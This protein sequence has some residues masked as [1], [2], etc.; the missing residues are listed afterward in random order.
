M[1]S[2]RARMD[3][4][5]C[6]GIRGI[7]L[8]VYTH[9]HYHRHRGSMLHV[10]YPTDSVSRLDESQLAKHGMEKWEREGQQFIKGYQR[11]NVTEMTE[12]RR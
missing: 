1:G 8:Y 11:K 9:M 12:T 6:T 2:L 10:P 3:A 5:G 7:P 4:I